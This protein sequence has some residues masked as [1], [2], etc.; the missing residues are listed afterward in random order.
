M[1]NPIIDL[2][3]ID[4][5]FKQGK[6]VVH[7]VKDVSLSIEKGDI[8]GI[9]GYSGAGKSTLVRTINLL[10]K[11]TDG[12]VTIDGDVFSRTTS[13]SCPTRNCRKTAVHRDDFPALQ[14]LERNLGD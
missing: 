10:Q 11:P 7:A 8:Y 2:Q 1:A 5:T 13:N 4:V 14:P 12:T 3:D 9:V 6:E